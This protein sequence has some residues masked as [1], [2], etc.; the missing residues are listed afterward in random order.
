MS[1]AKWLRKALGKKKPYKG[2][3]K[4]ATLTQVR[5]PIRDTA[6]PT[7]SSPPRL[8]GIVI[9]NKHGAI[10]LDY[11]KDRSDMRACAPDGYRFNWGHSVMWGELLKRHL[12]CYIVFLQADL[13]SASAHEQWHWLKITKNVLW[14]IEN[15]MAIRALGR[16][17]ELRSSQEE[18]R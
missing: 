15:G 18:K 6:L 4:T 9:I 16:E 1:R 11:V 14:E 2:W 12:G 10:V 8:Y 7:G 17:P 13:M 5:T 3:L